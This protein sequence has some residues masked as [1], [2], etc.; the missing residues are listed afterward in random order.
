VLAAEEVFLCNSLA[1]IWPLRELGPQQWQ[2]GALTRRL[3][4]LL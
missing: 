2:P 1:G 4:Q 3:Q